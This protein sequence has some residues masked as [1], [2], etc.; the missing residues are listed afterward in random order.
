M[1]F[2]QL[3]DVTK[4]GALSFAEFCTAMH[5][6]VLRVRN[7]ELPDQLPVKLQPYAPLIDFNSET[8]LASGVTPSHATSSAAAVAARTTSVN[9]DGHLVGESAT[10]ISQRN[11]SMS[12][13]EDVTICSPS[14][15][16]STAAAAAAVIAAAAT[17]SAGLMATP[18]M[19]SKTISNNNKPLV[20]GVKPHLQSVGYFVLNQPFKLNS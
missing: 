19:T 15:S 14:T 10:G 20:F 18:S 4:D 5:L 17:A 9:N 13:S 16:T 8:N 6:V 7:F 2:R 3:S 12:D 1:T 11:N